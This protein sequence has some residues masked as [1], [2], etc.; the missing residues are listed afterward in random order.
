M[1]LSAWA[2]PSLTDEVVARLEAQGVRGVTDLMLRDCQDLAREAS[3]SYRV[4]DK[5]HLVTGWEL[6]SIRRVAI[7]HHSVFAVSGRE[8]L[9]QA[10]HNTKVFSTGCKMLDR[11]VE[12]G[13]TTGEVV[14]VCGGSGEGKTT[15]CLQLALHA[16]LEQGLSVLYV[17]PVGSLNHL[18]V[19]PLAVEDALSRIKVTGASDVWEVFAALRIATQPFIP[20]RY[21]QLDE[22]GAQDGDSNLA[23]IK[24]VIIDSLAS[25]MLPLIT[26][27][28]SK[29]GNSNFNRYSDIYY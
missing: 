29:Q 3:V 22:G 19:N 18:R 10:I 8:L 6:R 23:K 7:A 28:D 21:G 1:R 2:C 4:G 24:L 26:K 17:D 15:L 9:H 20:V 11:L 13:L 14:E 27:E 25:V 5:L 16:A 12:G